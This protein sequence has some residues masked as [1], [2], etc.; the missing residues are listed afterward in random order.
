MAADWGA[1]RGGQSVLTATAAPARVS[2]FGEFSLAG[3]TGSPVAMT[4]RRSRALLAMLSLE[5]DQLLT[6]EQV[7][8]LLWPGRFEAQAKAS[9]R[10]CL[11]ELGK[12]RDEI[13]HPIVTATREHIGLVAA[14]VQTDFGELMRSLA[15]RRYDDAITAL[16][17]IGNKPLLDHLN[18]GDPFSAWLG[19]YREAIAKR[20]RDAVM[21]AL[22]EI[23]Q[24]GDH[25]LRQ[26]LLDAW[27]A[28]EPLTPTVA[29]ASLTGAKTRIA[30]L[31][32]QALGSLDCADYFADGMVDELITTLG[33]VPQLVVAGRTSSFHF[34]DSDLSPIGIADALRVSHLIEGSVQRQGERVRIHVH[35]ISGDT[36]FELWGERF[37]GTFDDVF[38]LQETVAQAVT[39]A[40]GGA[41][42]IAMQP[43]LV[44]GL[45]HS[46]AAYDLYLQGRSLCAQVFGDGI[47]DKAISLFDEALALDPDFAE[48]WVWLAE[49]HQLVA[50]Y[51]Q[52]LDRNAASQR[53]A[54]CARRAIAL[55]PELGYSYSLLG[56]HQWTQ[57][58]IVG[59]LDHAFEGYRR[60]P[61]NPAVT[62]RLGSF[63]IYCGRTKQ[64]APYV[65]D[66]IDR[67][68]IDPRKY[69]LLWAIHMGSGDLVAA[70]TVGQRVVDLGWP[71]IFL[72]V[73]SA[74]LGQHDLA[75]EQY[76]LSKK[77]VNSMILPPIGRGAMTP[78]LMDTYWQVGAKGI[79]S[80]QE[81][82]RL[83]Y[84]QWLE[85][86]YAT[87]HDKADLAITS[88]AIST[89]NAELTFKSLGDHISPANMLSFLQLWTDVDPI[90]RIWQHSEFIPFA[91]RI[92][93]AA[94]WD[95]YGWPD[96]LPPP[97]NR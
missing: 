75:I 96:L 21:L 19:A 26:R 37:D 55:S 9:L 84:F 54:D 5:P 45:T 16:I 53:M 38:A 68:P 41:L 24:A 46:K 13:G 40:I 73:A 1:E 39:A 48:C 42:G 47:L 59:A 43:P 18:F 32:F 58:D 95:K 50:V 69:S 79:C 15:G 33:Q 93:M 7:T 4:N 31:P 86:M 94:A 51:T 20:L 74:A 92:G 91:Q 77:L 2:L 97:S 85:M 66:A 61:E 8:R 78:E 65:T 82:D 90:R 89:G 81:A 3:P 36:G 28:R 64:A 11:L 56:V 52:C 35:L 87:L 88:P 10:Q 34:R 12:V 30:V 22:D 71:S 17:E 6:R 70:Q 60:E 63:L 25:P 67:D 49:A 72:A 27:T 83:I 76:L 23:E 80:G 44:R 14:N 57:N 62:M 29:A